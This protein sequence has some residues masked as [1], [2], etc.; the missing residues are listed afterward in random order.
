MF[1]F[2]FYNNNVT[3]C[4]VGG[5]FISVIIIMILGAILGMKLFPQKYSA[6]NERFQILCISILIFSMGVMLGKRDNFF[7]E[8][9]SIGLKSIVLA[10]VPII[11]S[12]ILV[13]ILTKKYIG[14][15]DD[16]NSNN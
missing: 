14:D 2:N 4:I 8:L 3:S 1:E 10:I 16:N 6:L 11:C 15:K 9:S 12:I 5:D 13:Y 7:N